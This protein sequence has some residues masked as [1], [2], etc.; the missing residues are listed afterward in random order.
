MVRT[1]NHTGQASSQT[2]GREQKCLWAMQ[3]TV[4]LCEAARESE[5]IHPGACT[6][7]CGREAACAWRCIALHCMMGT[8]HCHCRHHDGGDDSS[9]YHCRSSPHYCRSSCPKGGF[10]PPLSAEGHAAEAK[11]YAVIIAI[12]VA[13]PT[14]IAQSKVLQA[15]TIVSVHGGRALTTSYG[16]CHRRMCS[17]PKGLLSC[18][19]GRYALLGFA[20]TINMF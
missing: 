8:H 3:K 9:H 10:R 4:A 14:P 13:V 11:R 1:G 6:G 20:S 18:L 17:P 5:R 16:R 15:H 19:I 7:Q 2:F 12:P